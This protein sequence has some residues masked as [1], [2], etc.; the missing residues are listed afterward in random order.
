MKVRFGAA[1]LVLLAINMYAQ[2]TLPQSDVVIIKN[3]LKNWT[4]SFNN[5]DLKNVRSVFAED[6]LASYPNQPDQDLNLT[7]ASY[8][9]LFQNT[10][11]EMKLS[12]QV[13]EIEANGDLAYVRLNQVS[14]VKPKSTKQPQYAHDT[15]IQIWKKQSD[16]AWKMSRS[17]MFPLA[18]PTNKK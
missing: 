15:G 13:L 6:Y 18:I 8:K 17:V 12:L 14:E 10:F 7:M 16:G 4:D 9:R 3:K 11:L 1:L 5:R 2:E